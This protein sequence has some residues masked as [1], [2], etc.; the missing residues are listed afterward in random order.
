MEYFKRTIHKSTVSNM[1]ERHQFGSLQLNMENVEPYQ[2]EELLQRI[3]QNDVPSENIVIEFDYSQENK[4]RIHVKEGEK[5]VLQLLHF[6]DNHMKE[7]DG[8]YTLVHPQL[9]NEK[10]KQLFW[11]YEFVMYEV[12]KTPITI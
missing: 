12:S 4:T 9:S 1:Y 6:I 3:L 11:T 10:R 8:I 7:V 5:W 2:E